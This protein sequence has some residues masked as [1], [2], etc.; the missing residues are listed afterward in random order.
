MKI[1]TYVDADHAGNL[2]TWWYH[3]LIL[4]YLNNYLIIWFPRRKNTVESLVFGSKFVELIIATELLVSLRY[5]LR[6]FGIQ[7]D[8]PADVF[9]DNYS[10]TNNVTLPKSLM[11]NR[12]NAI[13]Y[14]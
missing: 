1:S 7:I 11:K 3:T 9:C 6:M 5:K 8:G 12:Q 4:I 14:H 2:A 10:V 13:F